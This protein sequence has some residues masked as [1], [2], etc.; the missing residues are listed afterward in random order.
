MN[1]KYLFLNKMVKTW[2]DIWR[3]RVGR[4]K[5]IGQREEGAEGKRA[6]LLPVRLP[7]ISLVT[8]N[9]YESGTDCFAGLHL[10]NHEYVSMHLH[11]M[12]WFA[13]CTVPGRE[14]EG[15]DRGCSGSGDHHPSTPLSECCPH[16]HHAVRIKLG[17][18]MS[19]IMCLMPS[20]D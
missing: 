2:R 14:W 8:M 4:E 11:L 6:G 16:P 18:K 15:G 9:I 19:K 1:Q 17:G 20:N 5:S 12:G 3:L 10:N 7:V 13:I